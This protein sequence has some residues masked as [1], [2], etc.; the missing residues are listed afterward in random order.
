MQSKRLEIA[1]KLK[2]I[3]ALALGDSVNLDNCTEQSNL[4]TDLG[5]NSV[6]IIYVVIAIEEFFNI[7]FDN[8]SFSDFGCVGDVLDYIEAHVEQ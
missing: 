6:G 4:T 3:L 8:V 5:L 7:R 2:E 1:E